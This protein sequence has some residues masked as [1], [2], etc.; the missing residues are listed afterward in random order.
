M[1]RSPGKVFWIGEY[2]VLYGAPSVVASV[3]RTVDV[4]WTADSRDE[5]RV[6][7]SVCDPFVALRGSGD[8]PSHWWPDPLPEEAGLVRACID[9]LREQRLLRDDRSGLLTVDSAGLGGDAK[10]GLGSSGAAA[11]GVVAALARPMVPTEVLAATALAAHDSWG[12][13]GSGADVLVSMHGG[14]QSVQDRQV[15]RLHMPNSLQ[16]RIIFTGTAANTR[17]MV[18]AMN[19]WRD[20]NPDAAAALFEQLR[21]AATSGRQALLDGDG[22]TFVRAVAAYA[23][24]EAT[25]T[26][27]SKVPIINAR[28]RAAMNAAADC[29]LVAKPSGAGGGDIVIAFANTQVDDNALAAACQSAGCTLLDVRC[30]VPG[31]SQTN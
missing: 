4:Q 26:I 30:D 7:T 2:A 1:S 8:A 24:L 21:I 14:I 18:R 9:A 16:A 3:D 12:K 19:A 6:A 28:V 29:G 10:Y 23:V 20:A 5:L 22:D 31:A 13:V 25:L 17:T 27:E 15:T 11:S